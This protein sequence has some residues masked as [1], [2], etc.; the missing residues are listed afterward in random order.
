MEIGYLTKNDVFKL[1]DLYVELVNEEPNYE[2]VSEIYNKI[3]NNEDYIILTAKIK[4]ELVGSLTAIICYELIGECNPY[5]NIENVIVAKKYRRNGIGRKMMEY[6][7]N[8]AIS[9]GCYAIQLISSSERKKSHK[10]Y[11]SLG[12]KVDVG[13]RKYF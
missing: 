7:E 10:F 5:M 4:E 9:K 1:A 12:Y 6:I 3:R 8:E 11:K 2:K 13:F